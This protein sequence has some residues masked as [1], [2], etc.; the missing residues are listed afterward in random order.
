MIKSVIGS[1][2]FPLLFLLTLHGYAQTDAAAKALLNNVSK[3]YE[4]YRTIQA[5]FTIAVQQQQSEN[6]TEAGTLYMQASAG[7]YHIAMDSQTLISDGKTAWTVLKQEQEVQ[8][9]EVDNAEDAISPVNIFTFYNKGYKYVSASDER[10]GNVQ[11]AV[12]ELSPENSQASPYFKIKLRINKAN[13]LIYD[14]TVFDK[15]GIR[16]TYT[17]KNSKANPA[18]PASKFSFDQSKYP[19]MEIVDLR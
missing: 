19:G 2:L 5:D 14:A 4:S 15:G 11:L 8:V 3:A 9:T 16:Y 10:A 17:I 1:A 18:I 12:V 13:N 6:Y 7:K